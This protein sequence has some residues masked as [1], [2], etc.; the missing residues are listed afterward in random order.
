MIH[1]DSVGIAMLP[2]TVFAYLLAGA[3]IFVMFRFGRDEGSPLPKVPD[4]YHVR[5]WLPPDCS[6]TPIIE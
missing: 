5:R 3:V 4:S 2:G 6:G 1:A